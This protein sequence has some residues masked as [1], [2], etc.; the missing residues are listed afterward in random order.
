M[1][2]PDESV[3][4]NES[5]YT[6]GGATILAVALFWT[7]ITLTSW[8]IKNLL[9]RL[10]ENSKSQASQ[11]STHN[12]IDLHSIPR[13]LVTFPSISSN[14]ILEK[15]RST[16]QL[17]LVLMDAVATVE[18]CACS[19]ECWP[20]RE[21]FGY[22]GLLTA[23]GLN[24]I[25]TCLFV[26]RDAYGSPCNPWYRYLIGQIQ[27]LWMVIS[28]TAQLFSASIALEICKY[29]WSWRLT[30]HHSDRYDIA[31]DMLNPQNL[32]N[33]QSDLNVAVWIGFICEAFG[34]F[35]EFYLA[36][37]FLCALEN[38]NSQ[39]TR[40]AIQTTSSSV[41]NSAD[42]PTDSQT[43]P[44]CDLSRKQFL[45]SFILRFLINITLVA[46]GLT[47]TGMYLNP[48]NAFIQSWGLGTVSPI[49]H[50]I[51]YWLGPMFGVWLCV[52]IEKWTYEY[53][54]KIIASISAQHHSPEVNNHGNHGNG[55]CQSD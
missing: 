10:F 28:W 5:M 17:L 20:I 30:V 34:T 36:I 46:Y 48:A 15:F 27:P 19:L 2:E 11:E 23:I 45:A 55:K 38:W 31:V 41:T 1:H 54:P 9:I 26:T 42:M 24:G 18:Q 4:P 25:R 37:L 6:S 40:T 3:E 47:W 53:T 50:I 29:W 21:A 33:Y 35:I 43:S 51:V 14:F 16:P 8:I 13:L 52:T 32:P 49:H 39:C 7:I 12:M 44:S 22:W